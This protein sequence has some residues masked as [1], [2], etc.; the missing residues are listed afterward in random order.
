MLPLNAHICGVS[1]HIYG[2][3]SAYMWC[4]RA[5]ICAS[6]VDICASDVDICASDVDICRKS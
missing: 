6:D 4:F 1:D 2:N 3:M 5:H